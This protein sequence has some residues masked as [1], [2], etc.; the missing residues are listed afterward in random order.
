M[1][2]AK[3]KPKRVRVLS[4]D[5]GLRNLGH[6]DLTL[7]ASGAE[8]SLT[9]HAMGT[10]DFLRD[11]G[12]EAGNCLKVPMGRVIELLKAHLAR[13]TAGLEDVVDVVVVETQQGPRARAVQYL[14]LGHGVW[15][16]RARKAFAMGALRKFADYPPPPEAKKATP[17]QRHAQLKAFAIQCARQVLEGSPAEVRAQFDAQKDPQHVAD[18]LLQGLTAARA[19]CGLLASR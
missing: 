10:A 4:Y 14:V 5:I 11:G 19:E 18:A 16:L 6:C 2:K 17:A 9:V 8:P 7:D 15:G 1:P 12:C 3:A 13:V